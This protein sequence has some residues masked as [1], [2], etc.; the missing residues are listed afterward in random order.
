M[1][2]RSKPGGKHYPIQGRSLF[3]N[4]TREKLYQKNIHYGNE[5]QAESSVRFATE[6]WESYE[7]RDQK[8]HLLRAVNEASNK[9]L[10]ASRNKRLSESEREQAKQAH[11]VLK[12]WVDAHKGQYQYKYIN[13]PDAP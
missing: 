13:Y 4:K 12:R 3:H 8:V 7:S 2:F 6:K 11:V 9:A 5:Y 1:R 10:V